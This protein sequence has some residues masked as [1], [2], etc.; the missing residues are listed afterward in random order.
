MAGMKRAECPRVTN[1]ASPMTAAVS[2]H[3]S[4]QRATTDSAWTGNVP[5]TG[6]I[7]KSGVTQTE[8]HSGMVF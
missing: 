5:S 1:S 8:T 2:F 7:H 3:T 4:L 6:A